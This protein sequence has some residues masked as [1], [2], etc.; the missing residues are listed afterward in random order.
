M[1]LV[2]PEK[3]DWASAKCSRGT[4]GISLN[5][6]HNKYHRPSKIPWHQ[7]AGQIPIILSKELDWSGALC[8]STGHDKCPALAPFSH[9][10]KVGSVGWYGGVGLKPAP[11]SIGE[12]LRLSGWA[13][14]HLVAPSYWVGSR[15]LGWSWGI[16]PPQVPATATAPEGLP[17]MPGSETWAG[18]ITTSA[19]RDAGTGVSPAVGELCLTVYLAKKKSKK[20]REVCV[21]WSSAKKLQSSDS[22]KLQCINQTCFSSHTIYCKYNAGNSIFAFWNTRCCTGPLCGMILFLPTDRMSLR[23][24]LPL[25][26]PN[27]YWNNLKRYSFHAH[28]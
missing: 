13:L 14:I 8:D 18:D 15:Q 27:D 21:C 20:E 11:P 3:T 28:C 24:K 16:K 17:A 19:T 22:S 1:S 23:L 7:S 2:I 6:Q 25:K 5:I 9:R 12:L 10:D 26:M 4:G